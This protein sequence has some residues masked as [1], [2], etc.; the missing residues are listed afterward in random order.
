MR[1]ALSSIIYFH[2]VQ[3]VMRNKSTIY[4]VA[5]FAKVSPATVSR[6]L[7]RTSFISKEKVERIEF[8]IFELGFRPRKRK[9]T[10]ILVVI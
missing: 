7:N 6:Y 8:A 5:K 4:D 2:S 1:L 9:T 10:Q 3:K